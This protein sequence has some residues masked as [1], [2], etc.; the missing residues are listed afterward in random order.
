MS[1][2][3]VF[4]AVPIDNVLGCG[5][6]FEEGNDDHVSAIAVAAVSDRASED[7]FLDGMVTAPLNLGDGSPRRAWTG[8][9]VTRRITTKAQR[10]RR[11]AKRDISF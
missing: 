1:R 10:T 8:V 11:S 6:S 7:G 3:G 4:D 2:V 5:S 9:I